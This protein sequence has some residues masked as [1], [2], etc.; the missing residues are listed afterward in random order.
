MEMKGDERSSECNIHQH[1]VI[2]INKSKKKNYYFDILFF[3]KI[4]NLY[5]V[6]FVYSFY[7]STR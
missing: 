2:F 1:F 3:L 7:E 4:Q 6:I 5:G